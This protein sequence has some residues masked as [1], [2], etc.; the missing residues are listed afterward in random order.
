MLSY[1]PSSMKNQINI[2]LKIPVLAFALFEALWLGSALLVN[3]LLNHLSLDSTAFIRQ[4]E[5]QHSQKALNYWVPIEAI[6]PLLIKAVVVAEDDAFF[7][8]R[9]LDFR[10]MEE[11]FET[12]WKRK[13]IVRGASTL[14]MQLAKNLY[15]DRSKSPFRKLNEALLAWSLELSLSKFEI[16]EM[17]LNIAEWGPGIF[18]AEAASRYYFQRPAKNLSA[19][20]AAYLA[21]LLPNPQWLTQ[22]GKGRAQKRKQRILRKMQ[23]R[24]LEA[25]I[26]SRPPQQ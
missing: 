14:S 16:L 5:L 9:G 20:Q 1:G 13:K 12:N 3:P 23:N 10:A 11:S 22:S 2:Y 18:G 4:W 25:E 19:E 24:N 17:Y 26:T 7:Q 15:L 21:A 6:S 8:H